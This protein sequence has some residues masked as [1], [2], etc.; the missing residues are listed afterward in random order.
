MTAHRIAASWLL[1]NAAGSAQADR[2]IA[3]ADGRIV[4]VQEGAGRGALVLP[5]LASA[6]DHARVVRLSQVGSFD[7]PL[8]AWLPYLSLVP[9]VDPW[10]ACAVAFGRIARGGVGATMA[11]YT[12]VQGLT[13]FPT[14]ARAVAKA[15]RDVG[16]HV[17]LAVHC[18]DLNPLVYDPHQ[19]L[20]AALSPATCACV[21]R[22]LLRP[23]L[24]P[25][26][27]VAMVEAVAADIEGPGVTV[28]Y[29]PAG[30][31]WCSDDMLRRIGEASVAPGAAC[32]CTCSRRATSAGG[33]T[34][35]IRRASCATLTRSGS[36]TSGSRS[37]TASG[38]GRTR[39]R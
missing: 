7:I 36:S 17:A 11:H 22:R 6:H 32:T 10:L 21:T 24:P 1:P 18:R 39:W 9:A 25:A 37:P 4:A 38:C 20:L 28:Q 19:A 26:E 33:P 35:P 34:A 8:E 15:A 5:A 3:V 31:Q 12:R 2:T 29:G 27:Q 14:E 16:V 23:P 13:D 30:V